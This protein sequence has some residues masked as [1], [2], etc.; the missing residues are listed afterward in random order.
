MTLLSAA[1][2]EYPDLRLVLL[3]DDPP[4]VK[5]TAP[6]RLL[7]AARALPGE[8]TDLLAGPAALH[9]EARDRFVAA[10]ADGS[11]AGIE[12]MHDLADRFTEAAEWLRGLGAAQPAVDHSVDFF[13]DHI[14]GRLAA[15]LALT[16][17]AL[18]SA[19]AAGATLSVERLT[20]LHARLVA[21]FTV[22]VSSFERKQFVS[23]SHEAN[24]AMNLNSYI[25]LM[26]RRFHDVPTPLGRA[27]ISADDG[28]VAFPDSEYV[29]TLD[30]DSV[31]LPEYCARIV[32]LMEQ[33]EHQRIAVAQ[34]PY[35][36]FPGSATRLE[37]IAGATTDVQHIV[38]QGMTYYDATFWVGANAVLRKRAL[39][40]VV[41]VTHQGDW[42]IRRYVRDRTVIEDTDSSIDLRI[43]GWQLLN[44]PERLSYSATPPDFGALCI[45]RRRWANGGLL[46]LPKLRRQARAQ[47]KRGE[48]RR[49][50]EFFLRINYM[51]SI[52]WST[53]ALLILL[54]Y[55][56]NNQLLN[57]VL[58]LVALPYFCMV[59]S[60]LRYCGYRR[61]DILRLYA[62]NLLL[63]PVN[64]A[65]VGNSVVQWLTGGKV[66][67]RR[68]PKVR[69]RTTAPLLFNLAP[70]ALVA[71]STYTIVKDIN[72]SRWV[73]L[74]YATVN[75]VL[76][77]YAIVAFVG[78]RNS[79][80]DIWMNLVSLLYKPEKARRLRRA[81]PAQIGSAHPVT[82]WAA[83]LHYGSDS[84]GHGPLPDVHGAGSGSPAPPRPS[85][86]PQDLRAAG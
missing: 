24:K 63:M 29:L 48:E 25:G 18:R 62:F 3:I 14:V 11:D 86:S 77:C 66:A 85:I 70:Y 21:I 39:D 41:D 78:V 67:F 20:Q 44:Y 65:G 8:I 13:R 84:A 43:H 27:L 45:Q 57:P 61:L 82:D 73:N 15:D 33:N 74:A 55:P 42:E 34:T 37:R 75:A 71:L 56:F 28:T 72:G 46:I 58:V 19:A 17:G 50:G 80:V 22:E 69:N 38:H 31:L 49:F 12:E 68:T 4:D 26:G 35:S 40:E 7:A 23:L 36:S 64:L 76:C 60:D 83:V 51:A 9:R 30:A 52:A 6:R 10:H 16:A 53:V 1:L 32:H 54:A 47:A 2:Q 79:L 5:Y 81:A 59:A